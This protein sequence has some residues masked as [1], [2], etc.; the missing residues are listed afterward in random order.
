M[1]LEIFMGL[2]FKGFLLLIVLSPVSL[3]VIFLGL[4]LLLEFQSIA[5]SRGFLSGI[6]LKEKF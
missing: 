1:D 5:M 4:F 2:T 6:F 3:R